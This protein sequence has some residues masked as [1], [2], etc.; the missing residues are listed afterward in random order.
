VRYP[1]VASADGDPEARVVPRACTKPGDR[2]DRNE[3]IRSAHVND[4]ADQGGVLERRSDARV[5]LGSIVDHRHVRGR[6]DAGTAG[7]V[8]RATVALKGHVHVPQ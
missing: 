7:C 1:S 3:R 4:P 5:R 2:I 8:E 6:R